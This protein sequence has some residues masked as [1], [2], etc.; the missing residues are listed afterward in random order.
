MNVLT[1]LNATPAC[2]LNFSISSAVFCIKILLLI[3]DSVKLDVS[4]SL[5]LSNNLIVV[6]ST[7]SG[8]GVLKYV[9]YS[10][11]SGILEE[12]ALG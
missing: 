3:S 6:S 5:P 12:D 11:L 10:P 7:L 9:L 1:L 2:S 4:I 8:E